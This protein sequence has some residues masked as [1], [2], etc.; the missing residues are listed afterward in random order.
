MP[1]LFYDRSGITIDGKP[2]PP[3]RVFANAV[4][5]HNA[6]QSC[7]AF[8]VN[9]GQKGPQVQILPAASTEPT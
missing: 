3:G 6:F 4:E 5:G 2:I 9:G 1:L 7:E 8:L